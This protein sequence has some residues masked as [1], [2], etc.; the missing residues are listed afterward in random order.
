M[1]KKK[2]ISSKKESNK[3]IKETRNELSNNKSRK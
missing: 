3:N 1:N 2:E